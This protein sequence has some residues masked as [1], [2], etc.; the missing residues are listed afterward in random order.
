MDTPRPMPIPDDEAD[1][2]LARLLVN[3]VE[4]PWWQSIVENVKD[5]MEF[6]KLPPL[7][8]TS[9][10]VPVKEIWGQFG[11][12]RFSGPASLAIHGLVI[13]VLL[14]GGKA[15]AKKVAPELHDKIF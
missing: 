3:D 6:N 5:L 1:H 4:T 8:T 2:H 11:N 15:I 7:Q 14:F 13:V 10:P 12:T 9:Q